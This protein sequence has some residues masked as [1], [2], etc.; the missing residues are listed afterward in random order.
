[1]LQRIK[2]FLTRLGVN[3]EGKTD[4]ELV[5]VATEA[6]FKEDPPSQQSSVQAITEER[7]PLHNAGYINE[8]KSTIQSQSTE[9][10][11]L[12][13]MMNEW[14]TKSDNSEK[15]AKEE[16]AKKRGQ[17][18]EQILDEA[19]KAGKI[20]ADNKEKRDQWKSRFE[21]DFE[22]TK[23]LLDE[24]P[25]NKALATGKPGETSPRTPAQ[26]NP[27]ETYRSQT[28][29]GGAANQK[30]LDSVMRDVQSASNN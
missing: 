7:Q 20:P 26:F 21:K 4:D 18:I 22:L 5:K 29:L 14:K 6:G 28:S 13:A 27:A 3:I 1:M 2:N 15:A 23:E 8:L 30:I 24:V 16:A 25:A 11:E 17:D 10:S 9:I 19:V 12:K